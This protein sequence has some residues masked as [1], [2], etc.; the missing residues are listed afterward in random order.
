MRIALLALAVFGLLRLPTAHAQATPVV[1][2]E[3]YTPA[4]QAA[5]AR[6]AAPAP[7][8]ATPAPQ[9]ATPAPQTAPALQAAPTPQAAPSPQSACVPQ[10]R[11][12]YMCYQGQCISACNPAC[13]A[14]ETCTESGECVA[15]APAQAAAQPFVPETPVWTPP[16]A[17]QDAYPAPRKQRPKRMRFFFNVELMPV[18]EGTFTYPNTNFDGTDADIDYDVDFSSGFS[19][20]TEF[21]MGNVFALGLT[22]RFYW[23]TYNDNPDSD[24][25]FNFDMTLDP[26][27]R[28][29]IGIIEI[30]I[31]LHVGFSYQ[32]WAGVSGESYGVAL[33]VTP[34]VTVWFLPF[35]GAQV[36]L[37]YAG[38]ILAGDD[39]GDGFVDVQHS[40]RL[41]FGPTVGF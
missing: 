6:Q 16:V 8:A 22:P 17:P 3:G 11:S 24:A 25:D 32:S 36:N 14:G 40:F 20:G 41:T 28:I 7:Q 13:A 21:R 31:P 37:G 26:T 9:A 2:P 5:P 39:N 27:F 15:T 10:C 23:Q 18:G 34:G 33:G 4:P 19:F 12:G 35:M 1:A 38:R 29:P 30:T